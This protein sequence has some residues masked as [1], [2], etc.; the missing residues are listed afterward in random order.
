MGSSVANAFAA[1]IAPAEAGSL[2]IE[3]LLKC[4]MKLRDRLAEAGSASVL[5]M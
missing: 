2:M 5:R 4:E 3:G 1:Q